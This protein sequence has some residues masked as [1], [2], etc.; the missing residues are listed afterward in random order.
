VDEH[1]LRFNEN[2]APG[3]ATLI[4]GMYEAQTGQRLPVG[5]DGGDTIEL[6]GLI[7]LG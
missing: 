7:I 1:L 5:P 6:P 2:A 3:E 4:A